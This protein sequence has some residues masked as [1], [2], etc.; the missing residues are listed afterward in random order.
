MVHGSLPHSPQLSQVPL[1]RRPRLASPHTT[2]P[3]PSAYPLAYLV[4]LY[5]GHRLSTTAHLHAIVCCLF[6]VGTSVRLCR[7][8][9][10]NRVPS[11][12][13][14]MLQKLVLSGQLIAGRSQAGICAGSTPLTWRRGHHPTKNALWPSYPQEVSGGSPP[15]VAQP[16]SLSSLLLGANTVPTPRTPTP[17]TCSMQS[18][19]HPPHP[20]PC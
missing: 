1:K 18:L 6:S 13:P 11:A 7:V 8:V 14:D 17:F 16:L 4:F 2:F 12:G 15:W 3:A 10:Y 19:S 5:R 20:G 9:G